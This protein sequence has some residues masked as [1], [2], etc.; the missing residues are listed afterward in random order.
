MN[1]IERFIPYTD[2]HSSTYSEL[3]VMFLSSMHTHVEHIARSDLYTMEFGQIYD[4]KFNDFCQY[5]VIV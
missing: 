5:A 4:G 1:L 2:K 3:N